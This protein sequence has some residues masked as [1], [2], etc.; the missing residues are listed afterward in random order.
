[1]GIVQLKALPM[2]LFTPLRG[3]LL[4][5]VALAGAVLAA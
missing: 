5:C 1:L 2:S 3:L 4:A